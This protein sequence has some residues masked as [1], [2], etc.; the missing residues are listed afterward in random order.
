MAAVVRVPLP[1]TTAARTALRVVEVLRAAGHEALWVGGCV[2]DLWLASTPKDFD[3]ATSARPEQVL[4][5][6]RHVVEVGAAFGVVRVRE[7]WEAG[8]AVHEIEVA[9]FR[10]DE[11]YSDGRRPDAVRFTNARADVARRDF[12]LNGLLLDPLDCD[13][14]GARVLDYVGGIADLEAGLL[15]AIGEPALRFG[16][17][18]LRLLR[19]PRFAARFGLRVEGAT[20]AA[21]RQLAP[22]LARVSRERIAAETCAMLTAPTAATALHLWAELGLDAVLW[23]ALVAVDPGLR[24]AADSFQRLDAQPHPAERD[25]GFAVAKDVSWPL[26]L[27]VL[28]WP[29][30]NALDA[31]ALARDWKLSRADGHALSRIWRMAEQLHAPPT[32]T[33]LVRLLREPLADVALRLLAARE[34]EGSPWLLLRAVRAAADRQAWWPP[35]HVTGEHLQRWGY[36]PGPRFRAALAA[37]EDAQLAGGSGEEAA[38]AA[39]AV[40]ERPIDS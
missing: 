37:A 36:A 35:L 34:A 7:R 30:R 3:V 4:G 16:E 27:A 38:V 2:R 9:T 18:A 13:D 39:R 33:A 8:A 15:R 20:A 32:G 28:A 25:G 1:H 26:A 5:L 10:A 11:G 19:A 14:T 31:E 24:A 40:L 17:D 23:P 21:I 12:T 6:F 22:T 29:V